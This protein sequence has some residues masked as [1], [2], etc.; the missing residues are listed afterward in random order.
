MRN[1]CAIFRFLLYVLILI[2]LLLSHFSSFFFVHPFL[3]LFTSVIPSDKNNAIFNRIND[4]K[5][6]EGTRVFE[7]RTKFLNLEGCLKLS[8]G[9]MKFGSDEG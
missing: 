4:V 1:R 3:S 7:I 6:E 9:V 8:M 2:F 5:A